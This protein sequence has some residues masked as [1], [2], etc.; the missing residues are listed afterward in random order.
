MEIDETLS[1]L[2]HW[3]EQI[4]GPPA[5]LVLD[6]I[7]LDH[8]PSVGRVW[9]HGVADLDSRAMFV[10]VGDSPTPT[11][12]TSLLG[13]H[14][15]PHYH[16]RG[17]AIAALVTTS[18]WP[19]KT[20]RNYLIVHHIELR[21]YAVWCPDTRGRVERLAHYLS[22]STLDV[23]TIDELQEVCDL[24]VVDLFSNHTAG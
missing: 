7:R 19:D 8:V 23:D 14:V 1:P 20:L 16:A 11:L 5:I 6:V 17:Q 4:G 24:I 18:G 3:I 10:A 12:V 13:S 22:N 21:H 9:L 15:L 2:P